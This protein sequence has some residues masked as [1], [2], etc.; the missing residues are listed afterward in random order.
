MVKENS[1]LSDGIFWILTLCKLVG[2]HRCFGGT[3]LLP[4]SRRLWS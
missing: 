2:W 1:D 3:W 4:F